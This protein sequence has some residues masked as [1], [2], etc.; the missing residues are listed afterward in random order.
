MVCKECGEGW[1][2]EEE[3]ETVRMAL[4]KVGLGH[5]N[6]N[7]EIRGCC[8]M[9]IPVYLAIGRHCSIFCRSKWDEAEHPVTPPNHQL[10]SVPARRLHIRTTPLQLHPRWLT[11]VWRPPFAT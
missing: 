7:A 3:K 9:L 6:K 1:A 8:D 10:G 5:V 11:H 4:S 2:K